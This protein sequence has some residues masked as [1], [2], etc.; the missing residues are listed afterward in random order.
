VIGVLDDHTRLAYCEIHAGEPASTVS[1]TLDAA[2]I[3]SL[4]E[5]AEARMRSLQADIAA[6]SDERRTLLDDV[7]WIAVRLEAIVAEAAPAEEAMPPAGRARRGGDATR[8]PGA[9]H[10]GHGRRDAASRAQ[11][12]DAQNQSSQ[13]TRPGRET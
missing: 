11:R 5:G 12:G 8:E 4:H 9:A 10:G 2:Q 6:I 13:A 3:A 7:R 1:A